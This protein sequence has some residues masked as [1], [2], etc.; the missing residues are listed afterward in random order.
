MQPLW[1]T[2]WRFLK[3][4]KLELPYDPAIALLVSF[5]NKMKIL[6]WKIYAPAC[7]CNTIYNSQEREPLKCPSMDEWIKKLWC[8]YTIEYY[9]AIKR[10]EI[11]PFVTTW[12]DLEDIRLSELSWIKTNTVW[13]H[14]YM[15][16]K[17]SKNNHTF[18]CREQIGGCQ[19]RRWAKWVKEAQISSYKINKSQGCNVQPGY[20][21]W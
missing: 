6:T 16:S 17:F 18:R 8:T 10:N 11:L 14:L 19:S 1:K 4:W 7:Y 2:V 15:E 21:D 12:I 9:S 5:P 13:S 20:Y 3:K